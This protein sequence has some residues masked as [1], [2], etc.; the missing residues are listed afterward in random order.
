MPADF[1]Q[2]IERNQNVFGNKD[3]HEIA[4][5]VYRSSG[6]EKNGVTFEDWAQATNATDYLKPRAGLPASSIGPAKKEDD[7]SFLQLPLDL[8]SAAVGTAVNLPAKAA[9]LIE[10]SDDPFASNNVADWIIGAADKY[11][12]WAAEKYQGDN[13][14]NRTIGTIGDSL[15]Y[16]LASSGAGLVAGTAASTYTTPAGG[17]ALGTGI[18]LASGV[19]IAKNQILRDFR[20]QTEAQLGRKMTQ[21][22]WDTAR[23]G[24]NSVANKYALWEAGGEVIGSTLSLGAAK[25]LPK[26]LK[27][28][29]AKK[30]LGKSGEWLSGAGATKAVARGAAGFAG[31]V[32]GEL[33]SETATEIGQ[34]RATEGTV[35]GP[36]KGEALG[37]NPAD[38][39]EAGKRVGPQ[40][41]VMTAILHG[42]ANAKTGLKKYQ[43]S[44]KK[45]ADQKAQAEQVAKLKKTAQEATE[46]PK[47]SEPEVTGSETPNPQTKEPRQQQESESIRKQEGIF[48]NAK[49][50]VAEKTDPYSADNSVTSGQQSPSGNPADFNNLLES[51]LNREAEVTPEMEQSIAPSGDPA[52]FKDTLE[53]DLNREAEVTPELEQSE[54]QTIYPTLADLETSEPTEVAEKAVSYFDSEEGQAAIETEDAP[55]S[56]LAK[57]ESVVTGLTATVMN[58]ESLSALDDTGLEKTQATLG[59]FLTNDGKN[60]ES[61]AGV[62]KVLEAFE[63]VEE[64]RLARELAKD[65]PKVAGLLKQRDNLARTIS[66]L[67]GQPQTTSITEYGENGEVISSTQQPADPAAKLRR[68]LEQIEQDIFNTVNN[69]VGD[70][71][72]RLTASEVSKQIG[73]PKGWID[74]RRKNGSLGFIAEEVDGKLVYKYDPREVL[75]KLYGERGNDNTSVAPDR[76]AIPEDPAY[77]KDKITD[78]FPLLDTITPEDRNTIANAVMPREEMGEA[79]MLVKPSN[80]K[81]RDV[82]H[83]KWGLGHDKGVD[84]IEVSTQGDEFG[85][86]FSA[87]NAKLKSGKTIEQAYQ[88]DVKGYKSAK[89]GK[90]NPPKT[91]MSKEKL[92][93][94]YKDLWRQWFRENPDKLTEMFVKGQG[95]TL[96]DSFAKKDWHG[97]NPARAISD[98]MNEAWNSPANRRLLRWRSAAGTTETSGKEGL[99]LE[100]WQA[101]EKNDVV[102]TLATYLS[103]AG[104]DIHRDKDGHPRTDKQTGNLYIE[105]YRLDPKKS[106][107]EQSRAARRKELIPWLEKLYDAGYIDGSE[108]KVVAGLPAR[109]RVRYDLPGKMG[110]PNSI[111]Q[112]GHP[113]SGSLEPGDTSYER[114]Q[115]EYNLQAQKDIS[116]GKIS[117][118]TPSKRDVV[119]RSLVD[120]VAE[121]YGR[122]REKAFK[123]TGEEKEL[124]KERR[125]A[126]ESVKESLQA[127]GPDAG[128]STPVTWG[129][130]NTLVRERELHD[131]GL[132]KEAESLEYRAAAQ[133]N[134]LLQQGQRNADHYAEM[135]LGSARSRALK[136]IEKMNQF[137]GKGDA[138]NTKPRNLQ[139]NPIDI[140][141]RKIDPARFDSLEEIHPNDMLQSDIRGEIYVIEKDSAD[142]GDKEVMPGR[143]LRLKVVARQVF[144]D[145]TGEQGWVRVTNPGKEDF[146]NVT[147]ETLRE[148]PKDFTEAVPSDLKIRFKPSDVLGVSSSRRLRSLIHATAMEIEQEQEQESSLPNQ[149]PAVEG[150]SYDPSGQDEKA[151]SDFVNLETSEQQQDALASLP[152]KNPGA[153]GAQIVKGTDGFYLVAFQGPDS[154]VPVV[155]KIAGT[156]QPRVTKVISGGQTGADR[157]GLEIA[158]QAGVETGGTAPKGFRTDTGND[159]SLRDSFGLKEDGSRDYA[160]RTRKNVVDSDATV[161]FAGDI[162][163]PGTRATIRQCEINNKPCFVNPN[164]TQLR[165]WLVEHNVHTLNVAGNRPESLGGVADIMRRVLGADGMLGETALTAEETG[166][167]EQDYTTLE[168]KEAMRE[169]EVSNADLLEE[170]GE[171]IQARIDDALVR[172]EDKTLSSEEKAQAKADLKRARKDL[173]YWRKE[174]DIEKED[175]KEI[176]REMD[177]YGEAQQ[178]DPNLAKNVNTAYG[179]KGEKIVTGETKTMTQDQR[180]SADEDLKSDI[181]TEGGKLRLGALKT[182][183]QRLVAGGKSLKK[184]QKVLRTFV[185]DSWMP[186]ES[187][188]GTLEDSVDGGATETAPTLT[189]TEMNT[190]AELNMVTSYRRS[191]NGWGAVVKVKDAEGNITEFKVMA[192]N[193]GESADAMTYLPIN[194]IPAG[195]KLVDSVD[196]LEKGNFNDDNL[197][198]KQLKAR[199]ADKA[200]S[201]AAMVQYF[202]DLSGMVSFYR[203]GKPIS[204]ELSSIDRLPVEV[205][206]AF[207]DVN[208]KA[209]VI[210]D[211]TAFVISD[212]V[213]TKLSL[214]R[215][216]GQIKN[217]SYNINDRHT[218]VLRMAGKDTAKDI[219]GIN[220]HTGEQLHYSTRMHPPE[221]SNVDIGE[222][223]QAV[224]RLQNQLTTKGLN[225]VKV[226]VVDNVTQIPI[227]IK[228]HLIAAGKFGH[229]AGFAIN[230]EIYVIRDMHSDIQDVLKTAIHELVGHHGM[231]KV[232]G[233]GYGKVLDLVVQ[234]FSNEV[235][236][237][238]FRE[239]HITEDRILHQKDKGIKERALGKRADLSGIDNDTLHRAAEEVMAQYLEETDITED[240]QLSN[241]YLDNWFIR[242]ADLMMKGVRK[243]G[244]KGELTKVEIKQMM[245]AGFKGTDVRVARPSTLF[246]RRVFGKVGGVEGKPASLLEYESYWESTRD[247]IARLAQDDFRS[248]DLLQRAY[249]G[250][251]G[252]PVPDEMDAHSMLGRK[253]SIV[254]YQIEEARK[255]HYQPLFKKMREN[256]ISQADLSDYLYA[257]FAGT[258]NKV[259]AGRSGGQIQDASGWNQEK[260]DSTLERLT[261]TGKIDKLEEC[262]QMVYAANNARLEL[263]VEYGLEKR[264]TI[265]HWKSL[266]GD[267]YVPLRSDEDFSDPG[268]AAISVMGKASAASKGRHSDAQDPLSWSFYQLYNTYARGERNYVAIALGKL[269]QAIKSDKI[270]RVFNSKNLPADVDTSQCLGYRIDG[271]Q[272]FID[273][274][275]PFLKRAVR[276][277]ETKELGKAVKFLGAHNRIM[278]MVN[279][280]LF[281]HFILT[282]LFRDFGQAM[283]NL[284]LRDNIGNL[285]AGDF[286][287]KVA[288]STPASVRAI[289]RHERG[290]QE[291]ALYK[292][293]LEL[294]GKTGYSSFSSVGQV[295]DSLHKEFRNAEGTLMGAGLRSW[296]KIEGVF[297]LFNDSSENGVRF[298]A[299]KQGL[300]AGLSEQQ[301]IDLSKNLTTNF[302]RKGTI[303]QFLNAYKLFYNASVQGPAI[304]FKLMRK[305]PAKAKKVVGSI[306]AGAFLISELNY[307]MAGNDDDEENLWR[308]TENWKK[309]SYIVLALPG[310]HQVMLPKAYGFGAIFDIGLTASSLLHSR[311]IGEGFNALT[312]LYESCL[313]NYFPIQSGVQVKDGESA[314]HNTLSLLLPTAAQVP[315]S[316]AF[317]SDWKGDTIMRNDEDGKAA[318]NGA[319]A[320]KYLVKTYAGGFG[321]FF[322]EELPRNLGAIAKGEY[323]DQPPHARLTRRFY[324]NVPRYQMNKAYWAADRDLRDTFSVHRR[325]LAELKNTRDPKLYESRRQELIEFRKENNLML[326]YETRAREYRER[327]KLYRGYI[328]AAEG[329][330]K[331]ELQEAMYKTEAGFLREY[332]RLTNLAP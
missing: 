14:W 18:A 235:Q 230:N 241:A 118:T 134:H 229:V 305:N 163:S 68:N 119:R 3:P 199:E 91:K 32:S 9:M 4:K 1:K 166:Q 97:V 164:E 197:T 22:E 150:E 114:F 58:D 73:L 94:E 2:Y 29:A 48:D 7:F 135:D 245:M 50:L 224:T 17:Y 185:E 202:E 295:V 85:S 130:A 139:K 67:S 242:L 330:K 172:I 56:E 219:Y 133:V 74:R 129:V 86:Q 151:L 296:D 311:N 126:V 176:K 324:G 148:D 30:V 233:K 303:G 15:S 213:R 252:E 76:A 266:Y 92:Y 38:A 93:E 95:K 83:V 55:A 308:K 189:Q 279:V 33:V 84:T 147:A 117:E 243:L 331:R 257:M 171:E 42:G 255:K 61:Q 20:H 111:G 13:T 231:K 240:M 216:L 247:R 310:N 270:M 47:A 132:A 193:E 71:A 107:R 227:A 274:K 194:F 258:K 35:V 182:A 53:S 54:T 65:N 198:P 78:P 325:K 319:Q 28:G 180:E 82:E 101:K 210:F 49:T 52:D 272:F 192:G 16:S 96:V 46:K 98:L 223:V 8:A 207:P 131:K 174:N 329:A 195:S 142:R 209:V 262:A 268:A 181:L 318:W 225:K 43:E 87:F 145:K 64:E 57:N 304:M 75:A 40:T 155:T 297:R 79:D 45:K 263:L 113:H 246:N 154:A 187:D 328:E 112:K 285:S 173:Y 278:A 175:A 226:N 307:L 88:M 301:A 309:R 62:N 221:Q 275:N 259:M 165:E 218:W 27:A 281:P 127:G 201:Y 137:F 34:D 77:F 21:A 196:A 256:E 122:W 184:L 37:W 66:E 250:T 191:T 232:F 315:L 282:N 10:D 69:L 283:G 23:D 217:Y 128:S 292:R 159:L 251:F 314:L 289:F 99:S 186:D 200:A 188:T 81:D 105:P 24:F 320:A 276:K 6:S 124:R 125:K 205:R 106:G 116:Y 313:T 271:E 264:K 321:K 144:N 11:N 102:Q 31:G 143:T 286:S 149:E 162:K 267:R 104:L 277:E 138:S 284:N 290:K 160:S 269:G 63:M 322:A 51:D 302:S 141:N 89:E 70:G 291:D 110:L 206:D 220:P 211:N 228:K 312:N 300:D 317:N 26:A 36:K 203:D 316:L 140:S 214:E 170:E 5:Q 265:N 288:K 298:A 100:K 115:A 109:M 244:F 254:D 169:S 260:I 293:Y 90:G 273:I 103:R 306:V 168:Q 326:R 12:K 80:R 215:A 161:I 156:P 287:K 204:V 178:T 108:G 136:F 280:T 158:Q 59:H 153:L 179:D 327:I 299:F 120:K 238:L 72:G 123:N 167:L 323:F 121:V 39:W 248:L 234:K 41:V 261:A 190:L 19:N 60:H 222:A 152:G 332:K 294:G 157:I 237:V 183:W 239:G 253:D 249:E 208:K 236:A 177:S 44:R 212:N 146:F 25:F